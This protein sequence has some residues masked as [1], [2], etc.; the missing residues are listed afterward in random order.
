M[1]DTPEHL[2]VKRN[3]VIPVG[4]KMDDIFKRPIYKTGDGDYK[5]FQRPGSEV[6]YKLPSRGLL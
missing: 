2:A 5:Y 4:K 1:S 3:K 6:A